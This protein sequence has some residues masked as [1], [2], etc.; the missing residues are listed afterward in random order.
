[1]SKGEVVE[2]IYGKHHK[3]EV[4]KDTSGFMGGYNIYR[5]DQYFKGTYDSLAKAVEVAKDSG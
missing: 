1:M 3:Y 4:T 5:D 2:T